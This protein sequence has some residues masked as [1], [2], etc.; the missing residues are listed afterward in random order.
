MYGSRTPILALKYP[1]AR[2]I[3]GKKLPPNQGNEK[4]SSGRY[5]TLKSRAKVNFERKGPCPQTRREDLS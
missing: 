2:E 4:V 5:A 3:P 1:I